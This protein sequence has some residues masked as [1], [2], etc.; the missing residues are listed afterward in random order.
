MDKA[1]EAIHTYYEHMRDQGE[2]RLQMIWGVIN[3]QWNN[4]L[5]RP[6][7]VAGLYLNPALSY[8]YSFR[9][10]TEVMSEFFECVQRMVPSAA[11]RIELSQELEQVLVL[12][13]QVD[14]DGPLSR[15]V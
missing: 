4:T 5:H 14:H 9:F 8:T 15:A 2:E 13:R 7:H 12:F 6:I 10:D 11:D 1:K 3:Q